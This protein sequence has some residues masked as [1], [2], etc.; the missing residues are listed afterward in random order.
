MRRFPLP[1]RRALNHRVLTL[2]FTALVA[3][4]CSD[5]PGNA[6]P[7]VIGPDGG[8]IS[9]PSGA[10]VIV[11]PGAM[12]SDVTIRVAKD[13][14]GAPALPEAVQ[15]AG[16]VLAITPHGS[17]FKRPVTVRL[18]PPDITL[19]DN[20]E[21]KIAK[22]Q[23][24]GSWEVLGDT[25]LKDGLLEAQVRSFSFF[26]VVKVT[27][28]KTLVPVTSEPFTFGQLTLQCDGR[29]CAARE[30]LRP[31]KVTATVTNNGGQLPSGCID[32]KFWIS[33]GLMDIGWIT[34]VTVTPGTTTRVEFDLHGN[35][36]AIIR[37]QRFEAVSWLV[38]SGPVPAGGLTGGHVRYRFGGA[39]IELFTGA[40]S[41]SV[42]FVVQFPPTLTQAVGQTPTLRPVLQGGGAFISD[43]LDYLNIENWDQRFQAPTVYD[44]ATVH[45]ERLGPTDTVWRVVASRDQLD[46]DPYPFG[47]LTPEWMY[48]SV[49][50]ALAPLTL[51]DSGALYQVRACF[52]GRDETVE[53]CQVGPAA[54]LTVLQQL[55]PPV[56]T[57]QP[58]PMLIT[59]GQTA[60]LDV[61]AGGIP[62]PTLQWQ[63]RP[64]DGAGEWTDVTRG[65]GATTAHYTTSPVSLA[66]DGVQ[67]RVLATNAAGTTASRFVAVFVTAAVEAP[68]IV[69]QPTDLT[70]VGGSEALFAVAARGTEA[71]S[72]QWR[73]DG[74][75]IAGANSP[76]LKIADATAS[77]A[78]AYAVVVSNA[79]GTV[80]SN[81][82]ALGVRSAST[83]T[84]V[85]PSIITQ[86]AGVAVTEGN[87]ATFAVGVSGSDPLSF[88]WRKDG[89]DI[90]GAA[91]A[92]YTI[93]AVAAADAGN[94][95]VRITN[96]AGSIVSQAATLAV[97]PAGAAAVVAPTI[98]TQ[99][100]SVVV[101]P[102]MTA[103]LGVGVQGSGSI[104]YQWLR[105][106]V[107]VP[108]QTEAT[109]FIAAASALDA[110]TYEVRVSN[111]AGTVTSAP[112]QV[113]LLGAPAITG[114]PA[115]AS[116]L[117]GG[118]A[119]FTVTATGDALHFQWTRNGVEIGGATSASYT[120]PA[121]ALADGGAA[122]GV[123]VF[124]AAGLVFSQPAVLTVNTA[125]V[126]PSF[127]TQPV[128]VTVL[129]GQ[130]ASFLA[131]ASGTP[132]PAL[133][134]QSS[135]DGG[136][137]WADVDGATGGVLDI[138]GA[139]LTSSGTHYR[140]VATN[141]AG[142]VES[143]V[144]VLTVEAALTGWGTALLIEAVNGG[145]AI[146]PQVAVNPLGD[147]VAV[148]QQSDGVAI[149]AYANRYTPATGWGSA[150]P[151]SDVNDVDVAQQ[152]QVGIDGAGN[153][154]A[155]WEQSST[156]G[157]SNIWASH[158][159][160]GVG[161]GA[162]AT[163]GSGAGSAGSPQV[164]V[165]LEGNA[166]AV[167]WQ[168]SGGRMDVMSSRF[169]P[170]LGWE[171]ADVID[172]DALGDG[173]APQIAL[174]ASGHA[175]A[176]WARAVDA[177]G[178][179]FVYDVWVNRFVP[180]VGWGTAGPISGSPINEPNPGPRVTFDR[181]G[182][183][184]AT[185]GAVNGSGFADVWSAYSD[186]SG[187]W[188]APALV[189]AEDSG[190]ARD[191][192]VAFDGVG[193]AIAVWKQSDGLRDNVMSSRYTTVGGWE[194]AVMIET[195]DAGSV[196]EPNIVIDASGTATAV[197]SHRN[198]AGFTFDIWANRFTPGI[199]WGAPL[200]IN[201]AG[202]PART[203]QLGVD[204]SGS[205][206]VVWSQ[207]SG[208][209]ADIWANHFR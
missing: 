70:V 31:M 100:G 96:A 18:P 177:G 77:D 126:L 95:S 20:Q 66:E 113:L 81:G 197:W 37:H 87:V 101:A 12:E 61:V 102:G 166:I 27:Y 200:M 178:F 22:G 46:A 26:Q 57:Q 141:D 108:G 103:T 137:T 192:R 51:A 91:A 208:V 86:P 156:I 129:E 122:F 144:A 93:Q 116:A 199:G 76:Q 16:D 157:I 17:E 25:V 9:E 97:A 134:W 65:T 164:A 75:P 36:T 74:Q 153:A 191:P 179:N 198:V 189:E 149:N 132:A 196:F 110:G 60:S 120:T 152:V 8:T 167:W 28:P 79:A 85:A 54:R 35:S 172:A 71:L 111:S 187:S 55:V 56:Y 194:P 204:A 99:P 159:T 206:V 119:S 21:L 109:L 155:V 64:A 73:K 52:K 185:W 165:D 184:I 72:Y 203:P 105:N 32:P 202:E 19:N 138:D 2:V 63:T 78:G 180:G 15:G 34:P 23:P 69:W 67:Y 188:S 147:A 58:R 123:V 29:P 30:I 131:A 39:T 151:I 128:D 44:H 106:G 168:H 90:A 145:A 195:N 186:T 7:A 143:S 173:S 142:S 62:A 94:Y 38:C 182:N 115:D 112:A 89:V 50:F 201:V 47:T 181:D 193:N 43:V 121:L 205:V 33:D 14:T 169:V 48:W 148:W 124:N 40:T 162:P 154:I 24:G 170:G 83:A 207:T 92:V 127:T 183:A 140:A 6:A 130:N 49:D 136:T 174:H 53:T 45:L 118:A 158:Y 107:A 80:V 117:E 41:P 171:P 175:I 10:T 209:S 104:S 98:V 139:A 125:S 82:A 176:V 135:V 1:V 88:Q 160:A 68:T 3:A 59:P 190:S 150:Q 133:Q 163:I 5:K 42:P 13:S 4:S 146:A 11:P 161:W 84:P 114:Q